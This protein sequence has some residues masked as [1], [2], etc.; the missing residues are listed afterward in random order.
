MILCIPSGCLWE[1]EKPLRKSPGRSERSLASLILKIITDYLEDHGVSWIMY[2]RDEKRK[3]VRRKLVLPVNW[4]LRGN[5]EMNTAIARDISVGGIYM[6]SRQP[7]KIPEWKAEGGLPEGGSVHTTRDD[8]QPDSYP[9]Y[10]D[11]RQCEPENRGDQCRIRR[12]VRYE[13]NAFGRAF[14]QDCVNGFSG[15]GSNDHSGGLLPT[16]AAF[17]LART[18]YVSMTVVRLGEQGRS[19]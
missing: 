6:E 10:Y 19:L 2:A 17:S 11:P 14:Y 18:R 16:G 12:T 1:F 8:A 13:Q 4:K 3:F 7:A 15:S 5:D 9:L